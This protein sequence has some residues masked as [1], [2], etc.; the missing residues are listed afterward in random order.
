MQV[1]PGLVPPPVSEGVS[2]PCLTCSFWGL[3]QPWAFHG[4][5]LYK[6]SGGSGSRGL[7]VAWSCVICL[8]APAAVG[9]L[10]PGA[11]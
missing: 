6:L 7:S 4:L 10:W 9:F 11:V 5:E 3:R 1:L 8:G 2:V